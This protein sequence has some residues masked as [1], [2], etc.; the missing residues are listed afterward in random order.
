MK[1]LRVNIKIIII[2]I[3]LLAAAYMIVKSTNQPPISGS[4]NYTTSAFG[5]WESPIT[6]ASIF[7][8]ADSVSYLTT[9]NDQ[10]Y[11]IESKAAADG[12]ISFAN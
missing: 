9:E 2:T 4:T 6:A 3:I 12:K 7:E 1:G 11:F 10:V 8:A 5:A